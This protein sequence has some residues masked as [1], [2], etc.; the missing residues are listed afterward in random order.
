MATKP[1]KEENNLI[2]HAKNVEALRKAVEAHTSKIDALAN[3]Q[4]DALT[5]WADKERAAATDFQNKTAERAH[6]A[7]RKADEMDAESE[8]RRVRIALEIKE[9]GIDHARALLEKE[10]FTSIRKNDFA[11]LRDKCAQLEEDLRAVVEATELRVTARLKEVHEM[12]IKTLEFGHGKEIAEMT[13][14]VK[15]Q[16]REIKSLVEQAANLRSDIKSQQDILKSAFASSHAAP[17]EKRPA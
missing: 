1:S 10:G 17:A 2:A 11:E 13:A 6:S 15:Q 16:D 12:A 14:T 9:H 7:K 5:E 8:Q 3:F 4:A